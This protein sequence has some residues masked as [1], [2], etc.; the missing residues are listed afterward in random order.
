MAQQLCALTLS[1]KTNLLS[2]AHTGWLTAACNSNFSLS[3]HTHPHMYILTQTH[4]HTYIAILN[5]F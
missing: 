5:I 4:M 3:D 1:Q 2:S